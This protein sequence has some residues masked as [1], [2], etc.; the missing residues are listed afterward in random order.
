MIS[1]T[2]ATE[3][4]QVYRRTI[5]DRIDAFL[6][7]QAR[8]GRLGGVFTYTQEDTPAQIAQAVTE[9]QAAGWAVVEDAPN[10]TL[11]IT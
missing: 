3:F 6:S 9:C 4:R 1:K 8:S 11:T 5:R 10:R 2:E 7:G